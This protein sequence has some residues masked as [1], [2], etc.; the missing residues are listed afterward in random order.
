MF[1]NII[2]ISEF[3]LDVKYKVILYDEV[4]KLL[5]KEK[6]LNVKVRALLRDI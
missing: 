1:K 4:L 3:L 5:S 6:D 2:K